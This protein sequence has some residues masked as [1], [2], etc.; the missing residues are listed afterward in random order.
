[1]VSFTNDYKNGYANGDIMDMYWGYQ[2]YFGVCEN[3]LYTPIVLPCYSNSENYD[4]PRF[5]G[6]LKP[7][8]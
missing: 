8:L 3:G 5:L 2:T 1:M 7:S 6:T 4:L